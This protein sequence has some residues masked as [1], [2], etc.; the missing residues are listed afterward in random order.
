MKLQEI[1]IIQILKE[2]AQNEHEKFKSFRERLIKYCNENENAV[3]WLLR[4]LRGMEQDLSDCLN[5]RYTLNVDR[6]IITKV[7]KTI[8]TE[9]DIIRYR[10][11]HPKLFEHES[12]T[13]E[14]PQPAGKW[15]NEKIDL[16]ELIYAI[17]MSVNHGDVTIKALQKCFEYIF[18]VDLGNV[19]KRLGE[20]D[21]RKRESKTGYLETL[22]TNLNQIIEDLNR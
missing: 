6:P 9:L 12:A 2:I 10:M 11:K 4:I 21:D 16:I 17:Q 13:K 7:L 1:E 19:Y 8:R 5:G 20:L 18:Q 15:T 3:I 14:A 22:V